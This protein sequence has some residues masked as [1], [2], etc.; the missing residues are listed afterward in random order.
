MTNCVM[1]RFRLSLNLLDCLCMTFLNNFFLEFLF[2]PCLYLPFLHSLTSFSYALFISFILF[3]AVSVLNALNP[4]NALFSL[5][6]VFIFLVFLLFSLQLEF[7]SLIYII[8]YRGAIAILFLFVIRLLTFALPVTLILTIISSCLFVFFLFFRAPAARNYFQSLA[9]HLSCSQ[10]S[11]NSSSALHDYLPD[12]LRFS[13]SYYTTHIVLFLRTARI[14]LVARVGAIV[15]AKAETLAVRTF[16]SLPFFSL[17][18]ANF[19]S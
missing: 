8:V 10:T 11:V 2:T 15:L 4:I 17:D 3:L 14:L 7:L 19:L 9:F 16:S 5:I 12:I 6:T 18:L 13:E 1:V